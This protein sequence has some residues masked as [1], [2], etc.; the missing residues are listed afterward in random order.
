MISVFSHRYFAPIMVGVPCG[1]KIGDF[2]VPEN[3]MWDI[4]EQK[5]YGNMGTGEFIYGVD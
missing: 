4:V 1:L 2:V 3:G 5:F